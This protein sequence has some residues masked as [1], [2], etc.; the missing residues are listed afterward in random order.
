MDITHFKS[1]FLVNEIRNLHNPSIRSVIEGTE[2]NIA[3][4]FLMKKRSNAGMYKDL[5]SKKCRLQ[6]QPELQ[7]SEPYSRHNK[8]P[9]RPLNMSI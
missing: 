5:S 4:S 7:A 8:N 6:P 1:G 2:E 9:T 3:P